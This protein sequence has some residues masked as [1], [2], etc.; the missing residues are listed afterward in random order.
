MAGFS[1]PAHSALA[2]GIHEFNMHLE[3]DFVANT[4][5]S[6]AIDTEIGAVKPRAAG[7]ANSVA[8]S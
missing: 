6:K 5:R 7:K 2:A 3:L 1:W 4:E 8:P